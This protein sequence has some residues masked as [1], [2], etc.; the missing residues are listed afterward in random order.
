MSSAR[1][2][3]PLTAGKV[4]ES[5]GLTSP[6]EDWSARWAQS[7]GTYQP[8]R[9]DFLQPS[10]LRAAGKELGLGHDVVEALLGAAEGVAASPAFERL[11][12][13]CHWLLFGS[14]LQLT[15]SGWPPIPADR[16]PAGRLFYALVMLSGLGFVRA[17]HRAR[18]IT[19]A[20]TVETLADL[21]L[22]IREETRRSGEWGFRNIG[23]LSHHFRA[24][25]FRL[26]RLQFLPG[27]YYH[28]FRFY[29]RQR[30]GEVLALAEDGLLFRADGQ[31][32]SADGGA[33]RTGLWRSRLV[34][35]EDGTL[36][37]NP[38][39]PWGRALGREVALPPAE[40]HEILRPGDPV[41]T[42][43]IPATGPMTPEGCGE[44]FA[45]AAAFF[46][47]HFPDRPFRAFT[48]HSWLLDPQFE[49]MAPQPANIVAFLSDWYLHPTERA[50]D[51]ATMERVFD[52]FDGQAP[53]LAEAP[54][55]TSLQRNIVGLM[56][57][58]GRCRDGGSVLFADDLPWGRQVYR[59]RAEKLGTAE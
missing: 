18:G 26:G 21:E 3:S 40:W 59:R 43:H 34:E 29:R 46:P 38:V 57:G 1:D 23:W 17:A 12:W 50:S 49:A 54:R 32:A 10:F 47:E 24:R 6:P 9:V 48:C 37:G 14:G 28:P 36:R 58:G 25:L 35:D 42:V 16:G 20:V 11:A 30:E 19:E 53:P 55:R 7:E 27:T 51:W 2:A 52:A 15:T 33:E 31:F 41:L 13:H 8:G 39:S 5:L 44:S 22:W 45:R 4:F 56:E